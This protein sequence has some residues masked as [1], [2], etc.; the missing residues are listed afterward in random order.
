[1]LAKHWKATLFCLVVFAVSF[2]V[3]VAVGGFFPKAIGIIPDE[4]GFLYEARGIADGLPISE[5]GERIS[6]FVYPSI[7][8]PVFVFFE[9]LEGQLAAINVISSLI[10]ASSVF[11]AYLLSRRILLGSKMEKLV[12]AFAILGAFLPDT[13]YSIGIMAEPIAVAMGLWW[14]YGGYRLIQASSSGR[15]NV[16]LGIFAIC[17]YFLY[18]LKEY[19]IVYFVAFTAVLIISAWR[20]R[21]GGECYGSRWRNGIKGIVVFVATFAVFYIASQFL[22][23]GSIFGNAYDTQMVLP[24]DKLSFWGIC[25]VLLI[26]HIIAAAGFVPLCTPL[27]KESEDYDKADACFGLFVFIALGLMIIVVIVTIIMREELSYAIRII[28]RYYNLL[29]FVA[30]MLFAKKVSAYNTEKIEAV[31]QNKKTLAI[32][33][34]IIFVS[35]MLLGFIQYDGEGTSLLWLVSLFNRGIPID[36]GDIDLVWTMLVKGVLLVVF[37]G[38]LVCAATGKLDGK[39]VAWLVCG[40]ICVTW[41][42]SA[43]VLSCVQYELH[44]VSAE[45]ETASYEIADTVHALV[46]DDIDNVI[47]LWQLP[48]GRYYRVTEYSAESRFVALLLETTVTVT[49]PGYVL[50]GNGTDQQYV[51]VCDKVSVEEPASFGLEEA[52]LVLDTESVSVYLI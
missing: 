37:I 50:K 5:L 36:S 21:N 45:E 10:A 33:G 20:N 48:N 9:D 34:S 44:V 22:F 23:F 18:A 14:L 27:F 38:I 30:A 31:V 15:R 17:T 43:A 16:C 41:M 8:A 19:Y 29:L 40:Y 26:A 51:V 24:S 3:H 11:P 12:Y 49:E 25:V 46:G 28:L 1:M 4:Y 6:K 32:S 52:D 35:I 42:I 39:K 2:A 7:I 47:V 13:F